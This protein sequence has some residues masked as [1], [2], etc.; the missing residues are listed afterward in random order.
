MGI[1]LSDSVTWLIAQ[2]LIN[3]HCSC[4][5]SQVCLTQIGIAGDIDGV[6]QT[7]A[8]IDLHTFLHLANKVV[9]CGVMMSLPDKTN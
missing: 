9:I 6:L 3:W 1:G 5:Q 2:H 8:L 7:A 4:F